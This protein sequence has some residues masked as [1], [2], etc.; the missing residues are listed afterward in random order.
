[1]E[2]KRYEVQ[3]GS[4]SRSWLNSKKLDV[5]D[6]SGIGRNGAWVSPS[7]VGVVRTAGQLRP[8]SDTQ[9]EDEIQ[10][11]V[12]N[13]TKSTIIKN[14]YL[15]HT[16]VPSLD[17]FTLSNLELE[18]LT[19]VPRRVKLLPVSERPSVVD[20]HGLSRLRERGS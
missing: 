14:A 4:L 10:G 6:E 16:L 9:L 19:A 3:V 5:E 20:N 1:M 15:S 2:T 11:N 13:N 8:L 7:S 17:H 12:S 18:G